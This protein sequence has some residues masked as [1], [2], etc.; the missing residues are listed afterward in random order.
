MKN[1]L[2]LSTLVIVLILLSGFT[3]N[4]AAAQSEPPVSA[5]VDRTSLTISE[6]VVL[7]VMVDARAGKHDLPV[8]PVLDDFE[9][10]GQ[11][12]GNQFSMVNGVTS[13]YTYYLYELQPLNAGTLEI[14]PVVV[15]IDGIPYSTDAITV[16]VSQGNGQAQPVTPSG[17]STFPGMPGFPNIPGFPNL[18]SLLGIPDFPTVDQTKVLPMDP[19]E[20]PAEMNGKSFYVEAKID[21]QTPY[22]GEQLI[23]TFRFY[24]SEELLEQPSYQNPAFTGL[25]SHPEMQQNEYSL[26]LGDQSYR[27]SEI[28]TILFPTLVGELTIDPAR[29]TIPDGFFTQGGTLS[30][31]PVQIEVKPL[32]EG[33]PQGFQ[34][35]VG[36]YQLNVEADKQAT[37]VNDAITLDIKIS[38]KGNL[39]T[40]PDPIWPE[41]PGWR[42]F[43]TQAENESVFEDGL[44]SSTRD[45]QR[46]LVPSEPGNLTIPRYE[47]SY[48]D[49]QTESYQTTGSQPI[50]IAV[51][52]NPQNNAPESSLAMSLSSSP[53]SEA[54][55]LH[56]IKDLE[57]SG[58]HSSSMLTQKAG[59][60]SLW[61]V[62]LLFLVGQY[63]WQRRRKW[64]QDNPA[65]LRSSQ[66]ARKAHRMIAEAQTNPETAAQAAGR[67]LGDYLQDKLNQSIV[68]L[69][70]TG[71][72]ALLLEKGVQ[73]TLV[74]GVQDCLARSEMDR[75]APASKTSDD[76][77]ILSEVKDLIT[78]L[79]R[80]L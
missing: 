58:T 70:H 23:Y 16:Q 6:T 55:M 34:G 71:L 12:S 10:L 5:E 46:T 22:L 63:T 20:A 64:M 44:V 17:S 62:P 49:P 74:E 65:L 31:Q 50:T 25:W 77:K 59:Y 56:P 57:T 42:A 27:V 66:A 33:A 53:D 2:K 3:T 73:P 14:G 54:T 76:L 24:Q 32:P 39:E 11:S 52:P 68:G 29:L 15:N 47:F 78:Q 13:N 18:S 80:V 43:D 26:K 37:Q 67:I 38:G 19:A 79:E 72:A 4:S 30:T 36:S 75:Y 8:L 9:I 69:T 21:K 28:Q 7:R 41:S 60:W 1:N 45:Y 61:L 48:F 51:E 35:A 40:L